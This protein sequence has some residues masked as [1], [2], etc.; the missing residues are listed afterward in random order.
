MCD[1]IRSV[2]SMYEDLKL[3]AKIS[4]FTVILI[5]AAVILKVTYT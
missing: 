5:I 3:R 2:D 4:G 1:Y